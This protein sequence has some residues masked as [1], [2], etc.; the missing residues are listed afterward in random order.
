MLII[1][2][3]PSQQDRAR[4]TSDLRESIAEVQEMEKY[5]VECKCTRSS[6]SNVTSSC[7]ITTNVV[8]VVVYG[9]EGQEAGTVKLLLVLVVTVMYNI[10]C[11]AGRN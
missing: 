8:V 4:F 11:T 1:F 5:R 6:S 10:A 7:I 3:A 9:L 2:T